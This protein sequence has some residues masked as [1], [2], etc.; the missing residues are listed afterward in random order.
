MSIF[1]VENVGVLVMGD[2]NVNISI[3][4]CSFFGHGRSTCQYFVWKMCVFWSWEIKMSIFHIENVGFLV[5]GDQN[6]NISFGKCRFFDH[7]GSKCQYF[8]WKMLFFWSW[9]IKMSIFHLENVGF[10]VTG[11]QNVNISLGK[12][13]YFGHGRS[14]CQYF[15][16]KM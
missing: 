14:K 8:I 15:T 12:C 16:W 7:G 9:E 6:V 1:H 4:E 2:Q 5:M 13:R 3:G 11:D 10:L